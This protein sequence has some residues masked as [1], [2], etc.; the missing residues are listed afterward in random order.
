[1]PPEKV[2]DYP[3]PP[4][5]EICPDHVLVRIGGNIL[6]EGN[7]CQRV[8]ETFH[9]PTYYLPPDKINQKLLIPAAGRSFCEWKGVAEYFDVLA[10]DRRANRA[11]WRYTSPTVQFKNI[12]GWFALYPGMMDGC[13][14]NGEEVT[15]QP[16]GFYGGW[17]SSAVEGPFKGDPNHPELI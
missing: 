10:G 3:R 17:I 2:A 12:A 14:I 1:M 4:R 5:L 11:V 6:F 9:P 8:L 15:P 13:W 16:G 7:G